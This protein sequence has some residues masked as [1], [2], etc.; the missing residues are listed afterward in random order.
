M[1]S[2]GGFD[3]IES[4]SWNRHLPCAPSATDQGEGGKPN[5][6][7]FRVYLVYDFPMRILTDQASG[8]WRKVTATRE[9]R[10]TLRFRFAGYYF[11]LPFAILIA[12]CA[13]TVK[14]DE[15]LAGKRAIEFA[16]AVLI[17]KNFDKGYEL[18]AD[19]GKRHISREKLQ[20]TITRLHPR[21]F[22][23]RVTAKEYQA[24]PGENA[25]WIY[26]VGQNSEDQFQYRVTME[27]KGGDYKVL[28]IDSG[29]VG[30]F[31]SPTS[32]KKTFTNPISTRP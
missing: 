11:A 27:E 10:L 5:I 26:L 13:E 2:G 31:F 7:A 17:E 23:T 18:L 21:G 20:E 32:E 14:H 30:R 12:G 9:K 28:T 16:Q 6:L 8:Y 4:L 25:M 19:G 24:M 29:A 1:A 22:P 3:V 15:N